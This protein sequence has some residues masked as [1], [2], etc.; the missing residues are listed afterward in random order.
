MVAMPP[1]DSFAGVVAWVAAIGYPFIF[2]AMLV[3][4]PVVTAA[5]AFA[6]ALNVLNIYIVLLLSFFGDL[7]GDVI[8]YAIGYWGREGVLEK[9]GHWLGL[10][11]AR[12]RKLERHFE[13]HAAKSL[14]IVKFLPALPTLG[15]ITA[16][17]V[18]V[19]FK[20]FAAIVTLLIIPRTLLFAGL[21]YYFGQTFDSINRAIN[22]IGYS[23][24]IVAGI[25]GILY[26]VYRFFSKRIMQKI[27]GPN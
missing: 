3:E 25:A 21:G 14:F 4:G 8:Y 18:R 9:Y 27:E 2:L 7:V 24:S 1:T 15:L 19:P 22:N 10:T 5:A 13:K 16:G 23:L 12:I 26:F 11:R 20:K 6:A 17:A